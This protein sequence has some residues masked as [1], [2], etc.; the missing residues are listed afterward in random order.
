MRE[1]TAKYDTKSMK[2]VQYS[3]Q[4]EN[5]QEAIKFA[6]YKF[7]A[8]PNIEIYDDTNTVKA[9]EGPIVFPK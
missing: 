1:Y 9:C 2:G 7:S 3:F 4:A 6:Q 5:L 8:C